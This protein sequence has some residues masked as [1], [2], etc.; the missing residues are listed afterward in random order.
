VITDENFP[1]MINFHLHSCLTTFLLVF[2][3]NHTVANRTSFSFS[4]I[5]P[6]REER[7]VLLYF[8]RSLV[9]TDSCIVFGVRQRWRA[10]RSLGL[11]LSTLRNNQDGS[12][13]TQGPWGLSHWATTPSIWR[14]CPIMSMGWEM[15]CRQDNFLHWLRGRTLMYCAFRRRIWRQV[16]LLPPVHHLLTALPIIF[17]IGRVLLNAHMGARNHHLILLVFLCDDCVLVLFSGGWC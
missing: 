15:L 2:S 6:F 11:D 7:Q 9:C 14:F 12:R 1:S 17:S 5:W 10:G 4:L 3:K 16:L 13:T 8:F